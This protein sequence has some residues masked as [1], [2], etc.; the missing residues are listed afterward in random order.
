M[1][2]NHTGYIL[3][4]AAVAN[5][6]GALDWLR[7]DAAAVSCTIDVEGVLPHAR[8]RGVIKFSATLSSSGMVTA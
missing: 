5:L 7:A 4:E 1:L 3:T 6:R 2:R 8:A